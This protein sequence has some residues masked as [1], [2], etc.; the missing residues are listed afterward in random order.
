MRKVKCR[1]LEADFEVLLRKHLLAFADHGAEFYFGS[2]NNAVKAFE[3]ARINLANRPTLRAFEQAYATAVNLG[4]TDFASEILVTPASAGK[5]RSLPA[6]GAGKR[7]ADVKNHFGLFDC[8]T[9]NVRSPW[10]SHILI[11]RRTF[12]RDMALVASL[13]PLPISYYRRPLNLLRRCCRVPCSRD[14][15]GEEK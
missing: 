10:R 8:L 6:I 3:L 1:P 2:G 7:R 14:L 13:P 9:S 4:E 5:R 12:L 11:D 15:Q